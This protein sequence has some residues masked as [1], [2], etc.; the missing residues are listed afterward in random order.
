MAEAMACGTPVIATPRGSVPEV[1][2]DGV[3]GFIV[4]V[5]SF[6]ARAADRIRELDRIDPHA[7]R[8]RVAERF[9]AAAM[10]E[11]YS[12]VFERAIAAG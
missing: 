12:R 9:S 7:C 11:G 1:V 6:A 2:E 5:E 3:T 10:V 4:D 8:R